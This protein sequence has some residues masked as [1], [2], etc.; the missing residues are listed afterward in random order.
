[1]MLED[2]LRRAIRIFHRHARV[3]RR[4][5]LGDVNLPLV[6]RHPVKQLHCLGRQR[7]GI[8]RLSSS[9]ELFS[10]MKKCGIFVLGRNAFGAQIQVFMYAG[11]SFA[12]TLRRS[13]PTLRCPLA[14][15]SRMSL[16]LSGAVSLVI[17]SIW[18]QLTHP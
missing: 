4:Q 10:S 5:M 16:G 2:W 9:L 11:E 13:V 12:V 17:A 3:V 1:M 6:V 14:A 18:W 8:R 7:L 15:M